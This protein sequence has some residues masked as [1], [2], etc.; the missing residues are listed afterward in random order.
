[1]GIFA[2]WQWRHPIY[3]AP[4]LADEA[5][6]TL[7]LG[8]AK[9][10]FSIPGACSKMKEATNIV[11]TFLLLVFCSLV[12]VGESIASDSGI[13][14]SMGTSVAAGFLPRPAC[15]LD[16]TNPAI[17]PPCDVLFDLPTDRSPADRLVALL[18]NDDGV[19]LELVKLGCGGETTAQM[20]DGDGS[21]CYS[22]QSGSQL[23]VAE[24]LLRDYG[25]RVRLVTIDIGVNDVLDCIDLSGG[26]LV[27]DESCLFSEGGAVKQV[28]AN[29]GEILD[30]L[31]LA[32]SEGTQ[33]VGMN[34][35]NPFLAAYVLIPVDGPAIADY[36][37]EL[38][39][40]FNHDVLEPV[41]QGYGV[42]VADVSAAFSAGSIGDIDFPAFGGWVPMDVAAV[43]QLTNMCGLN[44]GVIGDIHPNPVGYG[45][46][47]AAFAETL[48]G[49]NSI[50]SPIVGDIDG[51]R[52]V[53]GTD[54][55]VLLSDLGSEAFDVRFTPQMDLDDDGFVT[56]LDLRLFL[57]AY[58][59]A[60]E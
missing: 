45:L 28:T 43:C 2:E 12:S 16:P 46:I 58:R 50:P 48:R 20:I 9:V 4:R 36:S 21:A 57:Q 18:A 26:N 52:Q 10:A 1:M 49:G 5:L 25:D 55:L 41:Y 27:I 42:A 30:R 23:E 33:I 35:F 8:Q 60:R 53:L 40:Y 38:V 59:D 47:A 13:Y 39:S 44:R 15:V 24:S 7:I 37:R 17:N 32:A 6:A 11:K 22:E 34:Y 29:L 19:E 56:R 3:R 51:D 14:L 31:K 54:F